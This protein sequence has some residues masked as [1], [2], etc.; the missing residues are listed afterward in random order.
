MCYALVALV[1]DYDCWQEH[2][3]QTDKQLLLKE[4][5]GN[6]NAATDNA[7]SL[8]KAVL[9]TRDS[10]CDDTCP[11]EKHWKWRSGPIRRPWTRKSKPNYPFYSDNGF[12]PTIQLIYR[13]DPFNLVNGIQDNAESQRTPHLYFSGSVVRAAGPGR[14][15]ENYFASGSSRP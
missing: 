12:R 3:G 2:H 14:G 1:S 8:I 13:L 15:L 7:I 5:I 9:D 4:I 6:L 11:V 10:L